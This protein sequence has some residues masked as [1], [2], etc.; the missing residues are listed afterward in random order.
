M[1]AARAW[2]DLSQP[3]LAGALGWQ[4]HTVRR[5]EEGIRKASTAELLRIA[6]ACGVPASFMLQG[7]EEDERDRET[8]N[9]RMHSEILDRLDELTERLDAVEDRAD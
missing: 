9:K 2:A 7:F 6:E 1:R 8:L 5:I 4:R 3:E